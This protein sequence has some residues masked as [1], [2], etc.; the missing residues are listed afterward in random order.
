MIITDR[1][2][3]WIWKFIPLPRKDMSYY[4]KWIFL[5]AKVQIRTGYNFSPEQVCRS[6]TEKVSCKKLLTLKNAANLWH[7][8]FLLAKTWRKFSRFHHRTFSSS[9]VKCDKWLCFCFSPETREKWLAMLSRFS[10]NGK[11]SKQFLL[12]FFPS[13]KLLN[14]FGKIF[15]SQRKNNFSINPKNFFVGKIVLQFPS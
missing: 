8:F 7:F 6:H 15:F 13:E 4:F 1:E 2:A 12:P 10:W 14:L 9:T 5:L 11:L 3:L